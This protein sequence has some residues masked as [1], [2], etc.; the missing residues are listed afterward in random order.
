M[1]RR[2]ESLDLMPTVDPT[3]ETPLWDAV[4]AA[5]GPIAQKLVARQRRLT[6]EE[7]AASRE[8]REL[9]ARRRRRAQLLRLWRGVARSIG[10]LLALQR[11]A[12]ERVFSPGGAG[13]HEAAARFA[14]AVASEGRAGEAVE[15][16]VSNETDESDEALSRA[17]TRE[18]SPV[19]GLPAETSAAC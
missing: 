7:I 13:Y 17:G 9:R 16:E 10:P 8:V 15:S 19:L 6:A 4:L 11:R 14:E 5:L 1:P 12:T 3:P 18:L 2:A